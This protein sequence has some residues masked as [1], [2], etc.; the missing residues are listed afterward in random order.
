[1]PGARTSAWRKVGNG[2]AVLTSE[3][4]RAVLW[5]A[6]AR[7]LGDMSTPIMLRVMSRSACFWDF[8]DFD[9]N[10]VASF[11]KSCRNSSGIHPVPVHKSRTRSSS[12]SAALCLRNSCARCVTD[13]AVSCLYFCFLSSLF[14]DDRYQFLKTLLRGFEQRKEP[15]PRNQHPPRAHNLQ[16]PEILRAEHI[17]QRR[18]PTPLLYQPPQHPLSQHPLSTHP[19]PLSRPF[20]PSRI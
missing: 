5:R 12:G 19:H 8:L 20:S 10:G 1:M 18:A 17:L 11:K 7:A 16:I 2:D 9:G 14:L 3:A 15:I 6:R 13:A 4:R